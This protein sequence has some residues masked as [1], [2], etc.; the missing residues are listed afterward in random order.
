MQ[1][2]LKVCRCI[3]S[4]VLSGLPARRRSA[5]TSDLLCSDP[6]STNR[7]QHGFEPT[8]ATVNGR[9]LPVPPSESANEQGDQPVEDRDDLVAT[10]V[11]VVPDSPSQGHGLIGE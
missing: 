4:C 9:Y 3:F 10:R 11:R 7:A 1:R 5:T 2:W 6:R 8:T